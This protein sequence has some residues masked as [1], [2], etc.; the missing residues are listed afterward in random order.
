MRQL[1]DSLEV[2][3]P[4][5]PPPSGTLLLFLKAM[6]PK[7]WTKNGVVFA[8][9]IFGGL[10]L[11]GDSLVKSVLAF[12]AFCLVSSATYIINDFRDRHADALHPKKRY[13]PLASGRL[14]PQMA[15]T[16]ALFM[17]VG[18][19]V[20]SF[21]LSAT[22]G[23]TI[24]A[25]T[26]NSLLYSYWLKKFAIVDVLSIAI[27]FILRA[28]AGAVVLSVP[29]SSWLLVCTAFL[30][31]FLG[32][33]KRKKE[34]LEMAHLS[35]QT[36]QSLLQYTPEL[37]DQMLTVVTACTIMSY[38]MYTFMSGHSQWLMATIPFIFYG[39]FR[40]QSLVYMGGH[41][42]APDQTLLEDLPLQ[43][44]ILAWGVVSVATIY[45]T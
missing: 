29:I 5:P 44:T 16:A 24:L 39:I 6:R 37:L 31:L 11:H 15:L 19:L 32:F 7:Q 28:V 21:Q 42:E 27:G 14:H 35:G 23:I 4:S 34:L 18:T 22:L 25:Y 2:N 43:I 26:L 45:L 10:A 3:I 20:A 36:R 17:L 13:R 38:S 41:G 8:G 30:S 33:G 9:L 40:Y 1:D 12:V